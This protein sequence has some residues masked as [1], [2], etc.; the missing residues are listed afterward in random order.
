MGVTARFSK[1]TARL[2]YFYAL[3]LLRTP[4][5][6]LDAVH[7]YNVVNV[8]HRDRPSELNIS[9]SEDG[10]NVHFSSMTILMLSSIFV[11]ATGTAEQISPISRTV[12]I[13]DRDSSDHP[14]SGEAV[15]WLDEQ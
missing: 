6:I 10:S 5:M 8:K 4:N 11:R 3:D 12:R 14:W 13:S 15:S 9:W 1:T 2:G 7:I